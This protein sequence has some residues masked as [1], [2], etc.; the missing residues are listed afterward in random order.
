LRIG[1]SGETADHGLLAP[2]RRFRG[3]AIRW[4]FTG[5]SNSWSLP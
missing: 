1:H 4:N 3:Y 5:G 2:R